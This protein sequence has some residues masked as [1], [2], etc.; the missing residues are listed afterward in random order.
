VA[1][2]ACAPGRRRYEEARCGTESFLD[3]GARVGDFWAERVVP[4]LGRGSCVIIVAH[5]NTLRALVQRAEFLSHDE[6]REIVVPRATPLHYRFAPLVTTAGRETSSAAASPALELVVLPEAERAPRLQG[7]F[8]S[9]TSDVASR[10]DEEK[11]SLTQDPS[12][13]GAL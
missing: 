12:T 10:L 13:G 9:S 8:V 11:K 7:R 5:G 2:T 1:L 6:V 3:L 4:E